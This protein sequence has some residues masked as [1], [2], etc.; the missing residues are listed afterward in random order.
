[1]A[2]EAAQ[3]GRIAFQGRD[4]RRRLQWVCYEL[5]ILHPSQPERKL[6]PMKSIPPG[7]GFY[8][9]QG[10]SS[11]SGCQRQQRPGSKEN[12]RFLPNKGICTGSR[13]QP[14]PLSPRR[15]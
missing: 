8:P 13:R 9:G 2:S 15:E 11:A 6:P 5:H 1:M 4:G 12:Q 3:P 14:L 7:W 10:G